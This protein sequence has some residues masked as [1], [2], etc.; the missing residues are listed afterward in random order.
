[1][2]R[3]VGGGVCFR[4]EA[5]TERWGDQTREKI[6]G[7]QLAVCVCVFVCVDGRKCVGVSSRCVSVYVPLCVC[8]CVCVCTV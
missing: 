3:G 2:V 8:V 4:A 6:R 7:L 1:M 5:M